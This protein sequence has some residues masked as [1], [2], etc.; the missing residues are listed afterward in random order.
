MLAFID[1]G[2]TWDLNFIIDHMIILI[3]T[4]ILNSKKFIKSLKEVHYK[5]NYIKLLNILAKIQNVKIGI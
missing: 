5:K 2:K 3:Q 4:K 1:I